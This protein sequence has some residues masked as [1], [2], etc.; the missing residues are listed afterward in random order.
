MVAGFGEWEENRDPDWTL[1]EPIPRWFE[2]G[3]RIK[4]L[5]L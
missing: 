4:R 5:I 1:F 3:R 2:V